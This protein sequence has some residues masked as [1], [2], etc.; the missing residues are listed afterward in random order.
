[1]MALVMALGCFAA[2]SD[3]TAT[4]GSD[5][6][7]ESSKVSGESSDVSDDSSDA[8]DASDDSSD[9]EVTVMTY[10][11]FA[12][13]EL[14]T[15]VVIEAYVQAKQS[16]WE[17]EGQGKATVY[18]QDEDGA[19]FLYEMNCSEEDYAKLTVG[20]KIR[21]TGY[22]AEWS[23]EVEIVDCSFE[24][25]EGNWVAEPMDATDLLG[26]DD[27]ITHQN[28]LVSFKGLTIVSVAYKNETEG[29]DIYVTVTF[30]EEQ[31]DFCVESYL[32]DSETDV[33][34]AVAALEAGDVVDV[35]GFLYW[36]NG[37]NTHITGVTVVE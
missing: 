13:A 29:E 15:P 3:D 9:A 31:Y 34:K 7:D 20:T 19:Y 21:V 18:T 2:C 4:S 35:E 12:A 32:T 22:K 23:G 10:A 36:Y 11:E 8:S 14:D 1:M 27:L 17:K 33:Y 28:K 37:V 30:D 24:I 5:A 6:S 16:W 26:T 25:I